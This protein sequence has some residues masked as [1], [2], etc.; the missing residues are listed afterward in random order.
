[1]RYTGSR[2]SRMPQVGDSPRGGG[3]ENHDTSPSPNTH[4]KKDSTGEYWLTKD[5][6]VIVP[7][8]PMKEFEL[9]A[10]EDTESLT[11]L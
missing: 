11:C 9:L 2:E 4:Y 7:G 1:M 5:G 3:N 6:R 8:M 10:K